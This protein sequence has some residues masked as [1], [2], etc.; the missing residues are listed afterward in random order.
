MEFG[1]ESYRDMGNFL[2]L[3]FGEQLSKRPSW[4]DCFHSDWS[5][6]ILCMWK[7]HSKVT[8]SHEILWFS[9]ECESWTHASV[10]T[11]SKNWSTVAWYEV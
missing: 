11:G 8:E 3:N 5:Y 10:S 6:L 7:A 9:K 4:I 2:K 1:G